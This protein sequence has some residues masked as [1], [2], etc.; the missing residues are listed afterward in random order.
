MAERKVQKISD[1]KVLEDPML[2]MLRADEF[3]TRD[4]HMAGE[5]VFGSMKRKLDLPLGA[6]EKLHRPDKVNF[7]QPCG[8]GRAS[9]TCFTHMPIIL[10]EDD[11]DVQE[12]A[13][14]AP[15]ADNV[16]LSPTL[17]GRIR[18]VSAI[19]ETRVNVK[20]WHIARLPK[21]YAK[22]CC[23]YRVVTKKNV[24]RES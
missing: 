17:K 1:P 18:H 21:N 16:V 8:S 7:S 15:H 2:D 23:A 12:V 4:P 20:E 24:L 13:P 6:H 10:E 5:E 9:K 19:E 22:C 14:P 3:C 11:S